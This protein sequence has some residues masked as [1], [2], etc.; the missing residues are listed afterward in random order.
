MRVNPTHALKPRSADV[1]A[2]EKRTLKLKPRRK[3]GMRRIAKALSR[4][5]SARAKLTVKLTD[6]VGNSTSEKLS[7]KL[8]R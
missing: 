6:E 4:G 3:S 5:K 7:V 8:K 1:A 2:G